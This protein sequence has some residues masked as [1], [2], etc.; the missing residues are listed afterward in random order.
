MHVIKCNKIHQKITASYFYIDHSFKFM[1]LLHSRSDNNWLG[2]QNMTRISVAL[3]VL[4]L[5]APSMAAETSVLNA[6]PLSR[7]NSSDTNTKRE[8]LSSAQQQEFRIVI[9]KIDGKYFWA[10]RENREL[11]Y[12][13]S[14]AFH[15]FIDPRS[16]AYVKV[17]DK[18]FLAESLR[19]PGPRF[20]Y[21]EHNHLWLN[22]IT[23]WGTTNVF[24]P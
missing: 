19:D 21:L 3:L 6:T 15:I 17:F 22:T 13:L 2:V 10:S 20:I 1:L 12:T 7:V 5:T 4:F 11:F 16:G 8:A 18:N 24:E 14:G 23:Y 9:K